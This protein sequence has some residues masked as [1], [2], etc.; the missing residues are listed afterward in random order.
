MQRNILFQVAKG[1]VAT[2][3]LSAAIIKLKQEAKNLKQT[4]NKYIAI[5]ENVA[6]V[7]Q[8]I[9]DNYEKLTSDD[10]LQKFSGVIVLIGTFGIVVGGPFGPLIA[11]TCDLITS[12]ISLFGGEKGTSVSEIVEQV[13]HDSKDQEIYEKVMGATKFIYS[14]ISVLKGVANH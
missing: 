7:A 11:G 2:E 3:N 13:M 1:K 12:A 6:K 9:F 4:D 8:S 5:A 14:E 10:V